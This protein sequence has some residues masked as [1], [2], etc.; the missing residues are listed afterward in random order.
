MYLGQRIER[1]AFTLVELLVVI[2]IIGVL[3]GLL[4][5]AVQQARE[6]AR[7]MSCS[8][9]LKQI[10]LG[11]HNY[12]DVHKKLPDALYGNPNGSRD[13]DDGFSWL[14]SLL[15][16]VEQQNLHEGINPQG[17]PGIFQRQD[18]FQTYYPGLTRVP[19]GDTIVGT[20]RCPSSALPDRVPE[21]WF[22]PGSDRVGGGP[23]PNYAPW[24]S[25]YATTDYKTNGGAQRGNFGV[26][27]KSREGGG[28]PFRDV[29]D[30]LS[31]TVMAAESSYVTSSG[32]RSARRSTPPT[33][34]RDWPTWIGAMGR[35]GDEQ[36]RTNGRFSNP[37]NANTTPSRMYFATNDDAAFS[38]HSGG[39]Q[40]VFCDGSVH[41]I[42]ENI[43]LLIYDRL[44][45]RR[46]GEVIGQF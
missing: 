42:S 27:H 3:V 12:H 45:D 40:F 23:V 29:T 31:N 6:A 14:V 35:G 32:S 33:A 39:A 25:G 8:N 9:N 22:I 43:D 10:G 7:R 21:T 46:D 20:Y 15:P 2:A 4:L 36:V 5:P 17:A 24:Q 16:F 11:L 38:Y 30:G 44:Y 1:R 13:D 37:I 34:F 26:M 18:I 41:F 19:F 28:S